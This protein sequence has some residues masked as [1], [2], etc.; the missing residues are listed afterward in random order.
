MFGNDH[1][2]KNGSIRFIDTVSICKDKIVK[3]T[4]VLQI[5]DDYYWQDVPSKIVTIEVD[6]KG[7]YIYD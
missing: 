4:K 5:Y 1:K 6:E 7:K 2:I 3:R